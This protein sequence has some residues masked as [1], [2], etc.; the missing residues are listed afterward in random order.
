MT[1][2]EVAIVDTGSDL[3]LLKCLKLH[4]RLTV[5]LKSAVLLSE[6]TTRLIRTGTKLIAIGVSE[7]H[8]AVKV[9]GDS[10]W[11]ESTRFRGLV[12]P[13][14]GQVKVYAHKWEFIDRSLKVNV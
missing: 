1:V 5:L 3:V 14:A 12:R 9:P 6:R 2:S 10:H 11:I 4:T 13:L 7:P 8:I